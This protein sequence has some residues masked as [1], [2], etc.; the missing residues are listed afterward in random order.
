MNYINIL[1]TKQSVDRINLKT[2]S[3]VPHK[4]LFLLAFFAILLRITIFAFNLGVEV[5]A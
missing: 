5:L 4:S 3:M 2:L 1:R